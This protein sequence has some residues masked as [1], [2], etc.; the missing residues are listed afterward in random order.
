MSS[1]AKEARA[2][3]IPAL[4]YRDAAA[5]VDWLCRAFGFEQRMVVPGENGSIAHA[6]LTFGNGMIM[7]GSRQENEFGRLLTEPRQAGAVTQAV[8]LIV[9]DADAHYARATRRAPRSSS[10]SRPRTTGGA[11]TPAAT[12]KAMCG[13][14]GRTIRGRRS[15]SYSVNSFSIAATTRGSIGSTLVGKVAAIRPSRPIRYL[16]KFHDGASNGRSSAAHR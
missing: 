16:W 2:T 4:Q 7:L 13:R 15:R 1:P 9:D 10:I 5:A 3:V 8:Y 12:R 11:T 6:E 14:S